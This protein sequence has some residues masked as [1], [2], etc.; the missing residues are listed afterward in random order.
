MKPT[1]LFLFNSSDYAV[2]PWIDDGRF[3][4]VSVDYAD[5]DHSGA[6]RTPCEGHTVLNIDL[7]T[8][9]ARDAVGFA[10][11][12]LG[13]E[14]PSLVVSFPPCTDLAVCGNRSA[15]IKEQKDPMFRD[16]AVRMARLA[17]SFG[18][19][20]CIENPISRLATLWRK[21][22]HYWHPYEY[23]GYCPSGAHPEFPGLIA[24]MDAYPKKSCSWVGNG[25][26]M[27]HKSPVDVPEGYSAQYRKLGGKSAKTKYVRSLTPRGFA[28][29]VYEANAEGL[30][31]VDKQYLVSILGTCSSPKQLEL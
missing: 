11:L 7:S 27:P 20:Y 23:G 16:K 24:P 19:P 14:P 6:H 18:V 21:P 28:Q 31:L 26:V 5:T 8:D 1:V 29:A 15:V 3:N 30:L 4:V 25:F 17:E 13:F 9:F 22:N 2:R 12:G 10:L